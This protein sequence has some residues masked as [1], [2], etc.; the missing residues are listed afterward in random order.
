MNR[1][2]GDFVPLRIRAKGWATRYFSGPIARAL[3]AMHL[4]A[5]AI[6]TIGF[7]VSVGSAYL[8]SE[9]ELVIGGIVM[10]G[11]A[12]MDM[13]DGAVARLTGKATPF[14]AFWDSVLDR[15]GEA[16]VLFGLLV[17]YVRDDNELG[18]FLA[19]GTVVLSI[20]VSYSRAR[21]E[22]LDVP[23]D[24]GIMGRPERIVVMG[25]G[26]LTRYPQYA[27]G[28]IMAVSAVTIAQRTAHVWRNADH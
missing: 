25:V 15:L 2:T 3:V 8:L 28:V 6:T 26:L 4:S 13:F 17:Y 5:N 24:V 23:G 22:G 20:M 7:F 16:A 19:F 27:M 11:G 14:G 1:P 21:A 12:I 9:G 10:L 18:V